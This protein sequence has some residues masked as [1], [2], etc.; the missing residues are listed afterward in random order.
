MGFN[1][2]TN[3]FIWALILGKHMYSGTPNI[4][5][6]DAHLRGNLPY[7]GHWVSILRICERNP[8]GNFVQVSVANSQLLAMQRSDGRPGLWLSARAAATVLVLGGPAV[9]SP[10][11]ITPAT[12]SGIHCVFFLMRSFGKNKNMMGNSTVILPG[13]RL[14]LCDYICQVGANDTTCNGVQWVRVGAPILN[15]YDCIPKAPCTIPDPDPSAPQRY[16]YILWFIWY[17]Y[18]YILYVYVCVH[19]YIYISILP[20][21]P[22][23]THIHT[24]I[25]IFIF[26]YLCVHIIFLIY[27]TWRA[28]AS[29]RL[30]LAIPS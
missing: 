25:Y 12:V 11:S 14:H 19:I 26:K 17:I 27:C 2:R 30:P 16:A 1:V 18:I 24:Y 7:T 3:N 23:H 5:N 6:L 22:L 29:E 20:S 21:G 4:C 8:Q 15:E 28:L 9:L 10:G 13:L